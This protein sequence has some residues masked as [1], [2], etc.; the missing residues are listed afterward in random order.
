MNLA[1]L[2]ILA[3][4][5]SMDAFAVSVRNGICYRNYT[6]RQAFCT[7]LAF[8]GFQGL[9]PVLG[10]IAGTTFI[11]MIESVDHL[12]ALILLG[13]LGGKMIWEA[14]KEAAGGD[15]C[16]VGGVFT[17]RSLLLQAVATSI[18]ALAVGISLAAL[19]VDIVP[20]ASFIAVVT[21]TCSLFGVSLG[22]RFGRVLESRAQIFGGLI[23]IAIGLKIFVEHTFG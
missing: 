4:G 6:S 1:T 16:P 22:K 21:F 15:E 10:F 11:S 7:A 3:V 8:G 18:D 12:I 19:R 2:F 13:Y 23:L 17:V 5:L 14:R 20:A 9:M